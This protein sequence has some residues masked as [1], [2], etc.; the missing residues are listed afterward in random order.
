MKVSFSLG[1]IAAL[2]FEHLYADTTVDIIPAGS[3]DIKASSTGSEKERH[4]LAIDDAAREE[5][6]A[7]R[8][9]KA[10]NRRT[11]LRSSNIRPRK[12]RQSP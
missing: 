3:N 10:R 6:I 12:E 2:N 5:K 4:F 8:K 11:H 1:E 7:M 9:K